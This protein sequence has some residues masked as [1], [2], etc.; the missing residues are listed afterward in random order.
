MDHASP[1][2]PASI[3]RL[4]KSFA[5]ERREAP[6]QDAFEME[7]A[8]GRGD[9]SNMATSKPSTPRGRVRLR[10]RPSLVKPADAAREKRKLR[11]IRR[12]LENRPKVEDTDIRDTLL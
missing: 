11:A 3:A 10:A 9:Y 2:Q 8:P 12:D 5:G 1:R 6:P 7:Q 4:R